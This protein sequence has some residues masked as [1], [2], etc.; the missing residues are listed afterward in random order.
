MYVFTSTRERPAEPEPTTVIV[1]TAKLPP[2]WIEYIEKSNLPDNEAGRGTGEQETLPIQGALE[3]AIQ[4]DAKPVPQGD[5]NNANQLVGKAKTTALKIIG[6]MAIDGYRIDIHA[7]RMEG[8][9]DLV[10]DLQVIGADVTE[11]T[12]REWLKDAATVIEKK[13]YKS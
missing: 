7:A 6:G 1:S 9:G 10:K 8:I 5:S 12:L 2:L 3:T 13:K 11:K 4:E